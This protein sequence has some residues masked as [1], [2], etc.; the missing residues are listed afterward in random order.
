MRLSEPCSCGLFNRAKLYLKP[1]SDKLI[2]EGTLMIVGLGKLGQSNS[3]LVS[4]IAAAITQMEGTI[5]PGPG[6]PN[7]SLAY[8]NNNPGNLIYV[9]GGY[10]YP[11]ATPGAGGFAHYPDVATGQ[12]ALAHQIQVQIGSGQTLTQFFNQYAPGG[13]TNA[14]GGVQTNAATQNYINTVASQ[15]GIDPNVPLNQLASASGST[16]ST[17]DTGTPTTSGDGVSGA[18]QTVTDAFSNLD[19]TDPT[20]LATVGITGL[21]VAY[22][23]FG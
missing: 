2:R 14:A 10:N 7:G 8:Q 23:V 22:L 21:A 20:T 17:S 4:A 3:S 5:P 1:S 12:A 13:T 9:N 16:D 11:G 19:F 6:Y 15:V 18:V